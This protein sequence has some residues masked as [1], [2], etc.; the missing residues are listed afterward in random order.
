MPNESRVLGV[1]PLQTS[2]DGSAIVVLTESEQW[3]V[4][5]HQIRRSVVECPCSTTGLAMA[6]RGTDRRTSFAGM[7]QGADLDEESSLRR[8]AKGEASTKVG[9]VAEKFGGANHE[10]FHKLLG[11]HVKTA[12]QTVQADDTKTV[13]VPVWISMVI[14]RLE[15]SPDSDTEVRWHAVL[16]VCV[17]SR[18]HA[19]GYRR[20]AR[21]LPRARPFVAP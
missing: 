3:D 11:Y 12:S 7:A 6:E 20:H 18:K 1:V 8:R 21:S 5:C 9:A 15:D 17:S 14:K 13:I 19:S 2:D 16:R 4:H 10:V